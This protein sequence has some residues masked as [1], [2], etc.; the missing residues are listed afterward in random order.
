[1][2]QDDSAPTVSK[3]GD[4]NFNGRV[5]WFNRTQ[6][7]G[8]ITLSG[9][10][11]NGDDIF[12]YWNSL[13][14]GNEQYRYLVNGEYVTFGISWNKDSKHQYQATNVKGMGGGQLMCETRNEQ[15]KTRPVDSTTTRPTNMRAQ[16]SRGRLPPRPDG[17]RNRNTNRPTYNDADGNKWVLVTPRSQGRKNNE[18]HT[19]N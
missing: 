3:Y 10:E 9:E 4:G 19:P 8:F 14:V 2:S 15:F 6:G 12:V 5:K 13:D 11:F 17:F 16:G 7:W 18:N 1:M